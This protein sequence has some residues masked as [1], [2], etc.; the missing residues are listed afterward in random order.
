MQL[1]LNE[2]LLYC[3]AGIRISVDGYGEGVYQT[4]TRNMM[5]GNSHIIHFDNGGRQEILLKPLAGKWRT[6]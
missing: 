4:W 6:L 5:G 3:G 1:R 2:G